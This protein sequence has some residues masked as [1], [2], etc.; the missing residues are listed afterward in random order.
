MKKE[1]SSVYLVWR[2]SLDLGLPGDGVSALSI[3]LQSGR[4]LHCQLLSPSPVSAPA[5]TG[6][7]CPSPAV[8]A[9]GGGWDP[10][11]VPGEVAHHRTFYLF[12]LPQHH[13]SPAKRSSGYFCTSILQSAASSISSL[14]L[15]AQAGISHPSPPLL[16]R[17]N[18]GLGTRPCFPVGILQPHS[19]P[20][21][22][23]WDAPLPCP[24]PMGRNG[25]LSLS[26]TS[27]AVKNPQSAVLEELLLAF[28]PQTAS[29]TSLFLC[30][31]MKGW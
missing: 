15:P 26:G 14:L 29:A 25:L 22:S 24:V 23:W 20:P 6:D 10:H 2:V 5:E 27:K 13:F 31:R 19:M 21:S 3:T 1:V 7:Q 12:Q 9:Q 11:K 4:Q 17:M 30:F 28:L 16:G 18:L 8:L